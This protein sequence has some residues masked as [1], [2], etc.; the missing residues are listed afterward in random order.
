MTPRR[1]KTWVA[2]GLLAVAAVLV[3]VLTPRSGE[4]D[5]RAGA[6]QEPAAQGSRG[7]DAITTTSG[8]AMRT[9]LG[10][11]TPATPAPNAVSGSALVET[12]RVRSA[13]ASTLT[14]L[15]RA[16]GYYP[17]ADPESASVRLGRREAPEIA[18]LF[19]G[20][21]ASMDDFGRRIVAALSANDARSLHALRV[22]RG[23]FETILWREFPESRPVTNIQAEDAWSISEPRSLSAANRL[24]GAFAGR[25]LRFLTIET[26][27]VQTFT[28]FLLH[29]DVTIVAVDEGTAEIHR[30]ALA[31]TVAERKGRFKAL[32]YRD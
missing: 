17:P 23:E 3:M 10:D 20:G 11:P 5:R 30:I 12:G 21:A 7:G 2:S 22:T 9:T 4:T 32:L 6:R 29:R 18:D 24:L 13:E 1:L 14:P 25:R 19:Q 15:Q 27:R 16:P 28:N 26:S 8:D 31:P